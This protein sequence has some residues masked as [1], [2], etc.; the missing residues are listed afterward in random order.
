METPA[1][2]QL[3]QLWFQVFINAC[4]SMYAL[5]MLLRSLETH[6][7]WRILIAA[8]ASVFFPYVLVNTIIKILKLRKAERVE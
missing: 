4:M 6:V 1:K 3:K 7:A 2:P 5:S 8:V